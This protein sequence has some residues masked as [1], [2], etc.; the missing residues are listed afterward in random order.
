MDACQKC[1]FQVV[2]NCRSARPSCTT[3]SKSKGDEHCTNDSTQ[4]NT[5][6]AVETDNEKEN[7]WHRG[8]EIDQ[9]NTLCEK[10]QNMA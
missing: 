6:A 1:Q 2:C 9:I 5:P 3:Y 7:N 10:L 8:G 4:I